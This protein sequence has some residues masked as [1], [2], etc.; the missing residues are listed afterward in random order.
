MFY[1]VL[2]IIVI[3][4][5]FLIFRDDHDSSYN[6]SEKGPSRTGNPSPGSYHKGAGN[7]S[8]TSSQSGGGSTAP[9]ARKQFRSEL[10]EALKEARGVVSTAREVLDSAAREIRE[11]LTEDIRPAEEPDEQPDLSFLQ[12]LSYFG[13]LEENTET[14]DI[15]GLRYHCTVHDCGLIVGTVKAEPSNAHDERAQAVICSDGKLLGYIPRTQLDWYEDFNPHKLE[16]PFVGRIELDRSTARL[17]GEIKV[18]MPS[19]E[20]FVIEEIGKG[21]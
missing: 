19:S 10:D 18:I 13:I 15:A 4:A 12:R 9:S 7:R 11:S 17:V 8:T 16:C 21:L 3:V 2:A 5:L 14:F 1:A 20:T 6:R